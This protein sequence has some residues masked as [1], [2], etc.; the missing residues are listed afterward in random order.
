MS[1]HRP[2]IAEIYS[3]AQTRGQSG[4]NPWAWDGLTD[5]WNVSIPLNDVGGGQ[6]CNLANRLNWGASSVLSSTAWSHEG[7]TLA[8]NTNRVMTPVK[9]VFNAT[10]GFSVLMRFRPTSF[11]TGKALNFFSMPDT[12]WFYIS[13]GATEAQVLVG[14]FKSWAGPQ[15][16]SAASN[17][18]TDGNFHTLV[19]T[20][21]PTESI[22]YVD[23]QVNDT[24]AGLSGTI[25]FTSATDYAVMGNSTSFAGTISHVAFYD[26]V[27]NPRELLHLHYD[28][29]AAVR[30]RYSIPRS[31]PTAAS[32]TTILP[33][34]TQYLA[35]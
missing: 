16:Y 25:A 9:P 24:G 4:E 20:Y 10:K 31:P 8:A 13:K 21:N 34:I 7:V 27:L 22:L 29:D 6:V 5:Y 19:V 12:N 28:P 3:V 30:P 1:L 15:L 18:I 23:G 2:T 11:G 14:M 33:L 32:A 35:G 17:D 26:R